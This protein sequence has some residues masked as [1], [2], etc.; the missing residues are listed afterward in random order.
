MKS[1][2]RAWRWP[3]AGLLLCSHLLA[4]AQVYTWTDEK[5][6]KHF[7]DQ[8]S[9]PESHRGKPVNIPT[10]NIAQRFEPAPSL[11]APSESAT[12]ADGTAPVAS[13]FPDPKAKSKTP[14]G[15]AASQEACKAQKQAYQAS[16]ACFAACSR[17]VAGGGRNN[18][19]CGHCTPLNSPRC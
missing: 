14:T 11:V 16:A 8:V 4:M 1:V 12:T 10:P 18:A 7:G 15:V 6:R 2:F 5:G 9:T 17:P 19:R 13:S 3:W